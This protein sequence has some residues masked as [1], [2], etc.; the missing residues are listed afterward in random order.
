MPFQVNAQSVATNSLTLAQAAGVDGAAGAG[1]STAC[2]TPAMTLMTD[3]ASTDF[4]TI[5]MLRNP[6]GRRVETR[7][8][9]RY[10]AQLRRKHI[11]RSCREF[12][13]VGLRW[14]T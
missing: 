6:K 13:P 5:M 4:F 1:P 14:K 2:A 7:Y 12:N 3:A 8:I 10:I 9:Q 11:I